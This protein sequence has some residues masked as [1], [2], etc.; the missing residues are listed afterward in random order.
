MEARPTAS[1]IRQA[2]F[3]ILRN[4]VTGGAFLD[5][6]AGT[7]LMGFEALSRGASSLV[8]VEEN[9][10][11]AKGIEADLKRLGFEGEVI[12][13]D[14]RKVCS[15]LEP[16]QFDVIYADPPYKSRLSESVLRAVSKHELLA[17]GGTLAIEHARSE[18]LPTIEGTLTFSDRRDYGQTAI[19]FYKND[20]CRDEDV[21]D[22][23]HVQ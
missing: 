10:R 22:C 4:E 18:K 8:A 9:R 16:G 7:G 12:C 11:L 17:P 19:S 6:F 13:A 15:I 20:G 23:S 3:N 5:L 2:F 14:V 21:P 1:K